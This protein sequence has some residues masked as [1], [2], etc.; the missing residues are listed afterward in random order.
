MRT[1]KPIL[2][3][4]GLVA[5]CNVATYAIILVT[6]LLLETPLIL[7]IGESGIINIT[8]FNLLAV[9]ILTT[10]EFLAQDAREQARRR[11]LFKR[12]KGYW[13]EK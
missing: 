10:F 9:I 13:Y 5:L 3:G 12:P 11:D 4:L 1:L 7:K 8:L 2:K 6:S